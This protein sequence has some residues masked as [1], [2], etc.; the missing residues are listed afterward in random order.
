LRSWTNSEE[1]ASTFTGANTKGKKE[2]NDAKQYDVF[3]TTQS[4]RKH[5]IDISI[6]SKMKDTG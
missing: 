5:Q 2:A 6:D 3:I 1:N 4:A